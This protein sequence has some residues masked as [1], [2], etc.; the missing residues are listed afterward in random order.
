MTNVIVSTL[1][2]YC[3]FLDKGTLVSCIGIFMNGGT[4]HGKVS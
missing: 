4:R 3:K 1:A 2:N